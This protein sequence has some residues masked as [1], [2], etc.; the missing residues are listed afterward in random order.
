V[1]GPVYQVWAP[2]AAKLEVELVPSERRLEM[3]RDEGGWHVLPESEITGAYYLRI[4]GGDRVTDPSAPDV[5][6]V[7]GP[8]R[9]VDHDR[10][11]WTDAAFR[12]PPL[13]AG[14]VYE[15]HVGTFTPRGTFEAAIDRLGHLVELG[16][17]HVELMPVATFSGD[18]G[19]GYDGAAL[20]APHRAYGGVDGL[21]RFVDAAHAQGLAVILDVVYNHVGPVGNWLASLGPYFHDQTGTPWGGAVNFDERGSDEVRRFFLDNALMWLRDY[22]VDGLR[23]DA[24]HAIKDASALPFLEQLEREVRALSA[25]LRKD[26]VLIAESDLNDPRVV[27]SRDRCGLGMDAAWSDDFHHALHVALTGEE[28]AYY[29]DFHP[30]PLSRVA[31]ALENG[32]VFQG[33]RSRFRGRS[34][35]RPLDGV[36]L[37]SL[38]GYAQTHDQV[39]NRPDGAR[40]PMLTSLA[41]T[42]LALALV[43]TSPYTPMLFMGEEWAARTPFFYFTDHRDPELARNV[44]EGRARELREMGFSGEPAPDPQADSTFT[45]SRLDWRE[46]TEPPHAEVLAL[47]RRLTRL[48]SSHP[49]FTSGIR[50]DVTVDRSAQV[51]AMERGPFTVVVNLGRDQRVPLRRASELVIAGS[52]EVQSAS[53][54]PAL[55][56]PADSFAIV[57]ERER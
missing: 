50:P 10:F 35:G 42:K 47:T 14:V 34:H 11:V 12:P 44:R 55:D 31:T 13:G 32:W 2:R 7:L 8:C 9:R 48:R 18:R 19:W 3:R 57:R 40:L 4:D 22:H 54:T 30:D 46:P 27:R 17:T 20:Y 5:D 29:Q 51:L 56:M 16:V 52:P 33:Q 25:E 36:P 45:R 1:T 23:L 6:S 15:L 38:L 49:I 21:K 26:L 37:T 53:G 39:G 24:I 41:R 43:L 28:H